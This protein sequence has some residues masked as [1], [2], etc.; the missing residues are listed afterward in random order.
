M[1]LPTIY[2]AEYGLKEDFHAKM[3]PTLLNPIIYPRLQCV[4]CH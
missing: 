2:A 1:S 3:L 4:D